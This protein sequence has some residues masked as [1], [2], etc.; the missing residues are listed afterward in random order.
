MEVSRLKAA[1]QSCLLKNECVEFNSLGGDKRLLEIEPMVQSPRKTDEIRRDSQ[2]ETNPNNTYR[3][4]KSPTEADAPNVTRGE[5]H[6]GGEKK[7]NNLLS[8]AQA[9]SEEIKT[10]KYLIEYMNNNKKQKL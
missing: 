2:K 9:L 4:E 8:N 3:D 10:I 6:S 1:K 5:D 7:K